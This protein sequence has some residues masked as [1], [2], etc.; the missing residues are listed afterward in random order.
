MNNSGFNFENTYLHLPEIFY[1]KLVPMPVPDPEM[2]ILN[3]SLAT[4]LGLDFSE[5]ISNKQD[6][7]FSGNQ[8][9]ES[10]DPFAQAYAGHQFGHLT[11]LGDGRAIVWGEHIT[12]TGQ[13]LDLQFKGS[14]RTPYSRGGDGRAAL[15]PMLREYIISEAM[16]ALNIPTTRSL[17][18]VT[19]GEQVYREIPSPGAILTRVASSHIRVGTFQYAALQQDNETIQALL[20]YTIKR[21]HPEIEENQNK[22]L[23]LLKAVSEKQTELI[24]HWMRVGFIHGVMNTDNMALSGETIDYGPCAFMDTYDPSTVFSSID[25]GGRYAYANQPAIAQWNLARLAE[26]LLPL[27]DENIDKAKELAEDAINGFGV[28]YKEK[29]LSMLRTKIGLFGE[30]PEDEGLITDLLNWMQQKGVDYTNTFLDL[31]KEES[32]KGEPYNSDTFKEWHTR[33]Q[34][35]RSKNKEPL[36]SSLA[37]MRANNPVIIPRNHKVE[38]ALDAG[39]N[40]DLQPLKDLLAALREPYENS[41]HLEPYQSPPKPEEKVC[42]TFCGT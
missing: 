8:M 11:M 23:S 28:V 22:A 41:P 27:M 9:P 31:M 38:Q 20:D 40:S 4:D 12:P 7:L 10:A 2:V 24:T 35:R 32:P 30:E 37:L 39:I 21:H 25:H 36:E 26:T 6:D 15:G 16:H 19:T 3:T 18:V 1:T 33:W 13:R 17:A 14:G 42:Q 34:V 29:S 5:K